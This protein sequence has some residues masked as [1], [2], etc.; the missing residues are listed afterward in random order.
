MNIPKLILQVLLL[1]VITG[2]C[3][4]N[5]SL[6]D[7]DVVD[8]N[9]HIRPILSNKCFSCHGPDPESRKAGLRLDTYEGATALLT[10]GKR[11]IIPGKTHES[12]LVR[13]ISSKAPDQIMPPFEAKKPLTGQEIHL[14]KKWVQQG[15]HWKKHWA[16][17]P[18]QLPK[19]PQIKKNDLIVNEIDAFVQARLIPKALQPALPAEKNELLRRLSFV[20]TGLPP[21]KELLDSF[22]KD[23]SPDAYEK[24]VDQ[25]LNSSG[26][27][28]KWARHWMDLARYAETMGHEFDYA[29]IGAWVYRDYLIRA[30]NEDVP[31]DQLVKEQLAGDLLPSP[32]INPEN[33]NNESLK[34]LVF[35]TLG[36]GKHSPVDIKAEEAAR[37][38]NAI[39]VIS[40]TF[41]GLTVACAKCH[42]HKF[43][44]IPTSDYYALYGIL[45]SS[46]YMIYPSNTKAFQQPVLDSIQQLKQE[47]KTWIAQ[48]NGYNPN[49]APKATPVSFHSDKERPGSFYALSNWSVHG[50]AF[51]NT[52]GKPV[53]ENGQLAYFDTEKISS[54]GFG[55][56]I[57]GSATSPNFIIDFDT[58]IVR[59]AGNHSSLRIIIDNF[60][61]IQDPIYGELEEKL[62]QESQKDFVI[63]LAP[64]KG[65]KAYIELLNGTYRNHQYSIHPDAWAE[66]TAISFIKNGKMLPLPAT[67]AYDYPKEE[68]PHLL[69]KM[70][71]SKL[72]PLQVNKLNHALQNGT[73]KRKYT[74]V[75][76]LL[77]RL[78]ERKVP[79]KDSIFLRGLSAGNLLESPVFI[80]GN[81]LTPSDYSVPHNFLTQILPKTAFNHKLPERLALAESII[82]PDNPLTARVMVNRI[83]KYLFGVGLVATSD[84][85]GLQGQPPSHPELLDY[86]A[87]KFIQEGWSIKKM[88]KY[89]VSSHTFRQGSIFS[90]QA[91]K[92]DP[93]N[94]LLSHYSIHR[95]EAEPI[96][97]AILAV[98]GAL[99]T[100]LYGPP[101][102]VH[103]TEF[104]NGRGRPKQGPIDGD[105][106]RSIYVSVRRNFL[107]PFMLAF[108]MPVPFSTLGDRNITNVPAQS[109][110]LMNDPF[111]L[112][113]AKRWAEKLT[114]KPFSFEEKIQDVYLTAFSRHP[115][116]EEL[117]AAYLFFDLQS[118]AYKD[119]ENKERQQNIWADY[120]HSIFNTK[121]FIYVK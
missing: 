75:K 49:R 59:A 83:W 113:M 45:E 92:A 117:E 56:G 97:D 87:L 66:I 20:L 63:N 74:K 102:P 36:E 11:A 61:Q 98:S 17:I 32:R 57:T 52:L 112:E 88:I 8:F 85:F 31:Y 108:D 55:A 65:H 3:K 93:E 64:W 46:R 26:F 22:L 79:L 14:L 105:G 4:N 58:L 53:F 50:A 38:D 13:R 30:F 1:L 116:A 68:I 9:D 110:T 28:E 2:G 103:L 10:S 62:N 91:K 109:L 60:Q 6:E 41:Q 90:E 16:F 106:R 19:T 120:C 99:D 104:M 42:D 78:N 48:E 51:E 29:S 121:E 12:E 76:P 67:L 71:V 24:V 35:L 115:L 70:T 18:P 119:L 54:K 107:S 111:V 23:P 47:I 15:A 37:F 80:R 94:K 43:D 84:N 27:G 100:A 69:G 77:D 82:A 39:D 95:L 89:M 21:N 114:M 96:R 72:N 5:D 7:P 73:I 101:V 44:P 34:G 40:K 86:L 81:H 33:N 25:L 118:E